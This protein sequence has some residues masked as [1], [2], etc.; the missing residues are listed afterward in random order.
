MNGKNQI[1]IGDLA[2]GTGTKVVTVRYYEQIGMLPVP[3][4]RQETT[5]PIATNICAACGSFAAVGIWGLHPIKFAIFCGW[6]RGKMRS[7]QGWTALRPSI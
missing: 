3:S 6:L 5:G 7:A 4:E 1:G 2:K